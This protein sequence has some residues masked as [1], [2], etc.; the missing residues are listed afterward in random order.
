MYLEHLSFFSYYGVH[1]PAR[2]VALL[3]RP[4]LFRAVLGHGALGRVYAR[5]RLYALSRIHARLRF[6]FQREFYESADD[7]HLRNRHHSGSAVGVHAHLQ[8]RAQVVRRGRRSKGAAAGAGKIDTDFRI[9]EKQAECSRI[10]TDA[11]IL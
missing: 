3:I 1:L 4:L 8:A 5:S 10:Q 11:G 6:K 9:R 2:A 7:L